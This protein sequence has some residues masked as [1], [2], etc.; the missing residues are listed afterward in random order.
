MAVV[1]PVDTLNESIQSLADKMRGN[2]EHQVCRD[3]LY[4]LKCTLTIFDSKKFCDH[5]KKKKLKNYTL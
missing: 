1:V 5:E 4:Q 3:F 2:T